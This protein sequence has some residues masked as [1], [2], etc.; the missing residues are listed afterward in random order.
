MEPFDVPITAVGISNERRQREMNMRSTTLLALVPLL[1]A[2]LAFPA[3][4]QQ[5]SSSTGQG[6][7]QTQ[8]TDGTASTRFSL[9]GKFLKRPA[10]D[11][12]NPPVLAIDCGR[13]RGSKGRLI[14]GN[15][16]VGVPLKIN[17]VEP[18]EIHGTS[19]YPKVFVQVRVDDEAKKD[20]RQWTPGKDKTSAV[21]AKYSLKKMLSAHTVE[22]TTQDDAGNDVV[23]QFDVPSDSKAVEAAC[24]VDTK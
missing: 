13:G 17:Y 8:V 4:A 19:Y 9:T 12:S 22:I 23:M 24:D 16:Q 3:R 15:L 21:F 2:S 18:S 11:V 1:W 14:N 10:G 5:Q 20:K 6:W 7:R